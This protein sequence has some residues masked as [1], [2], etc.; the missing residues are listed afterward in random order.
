MVG[1]IIKFFVFFLN[2]FGNKVFYFLLLLI[3][4]IWAFITVIKKLAIFDK[5]GGFILAFGIVL[6]IVLIWILVSFSKK[7]TIFNQQKNNIPVG[8]IYGDTK[9]GQVFVADY[10][11]L[12]IIE[13]LS[14]LIS[15]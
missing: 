2:I 9:I 6:M 14:C 15:F 8:E 12:F 3:I 13:V 5:K 4:F 7:I 10:N 11:N 1:N